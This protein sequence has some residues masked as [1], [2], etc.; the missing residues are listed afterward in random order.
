MW[1]RCLTPPHP[2]FFHLFLALRFGKRF[3]KLRHFLASFCCP[4]LMDSACQSCHSGLRRHQISSDSV[5]HPAGGKF[6]RML[7]EEGKRTSLASLWCPPPLWRCPPA[8]FTFEFLSRPNRSVVKYTLKKV[9]NSWILHRNIFQPVPITG[10]KVS[11]LG[12]KVAARKKR[13]KKKKGDRG[14]DIPC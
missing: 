7:E 5:L 8:L 3:T 14:I 11:L 4:S 6:L 12:G 9:M 1:R 13:K 2:W 10:G